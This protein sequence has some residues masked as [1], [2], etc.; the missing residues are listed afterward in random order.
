[1]TSIESLR[2]GSRCVKFITKQYLVFFPN[3]IIINFIFQCFSIILKNNLVI[4]KKSVYYII[5]C[6]SKIKC[7]K[8]GNPS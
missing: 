2:M 7:T 8:R 1:M 6:K 4:K 3:M 5:A